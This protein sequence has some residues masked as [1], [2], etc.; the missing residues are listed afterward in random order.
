MK[1]VKSL[2]F[3]YF[4]ILTLP[5]LMSGGSSVYTWSEWNHEQIRA[6][7]FKRRDTWQQKKR[8]GWRP[9]S[10]KNKTSWTSAQAA[11]RHITESPPKLTLFSSEN[12]FAGAT[13]EQ[14][15][16]PPHVLHMRYLRIFEDRAIV[17]ARATAKWFTY[18]CH[19]LCLSPILP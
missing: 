11:T 2:S 17:A 7:Q 10:K 12:G 15:I 5:C 13:L 14:L 8:S 6:D 16:I 4:S 18:R 9:S 19:V 3:K 1:I